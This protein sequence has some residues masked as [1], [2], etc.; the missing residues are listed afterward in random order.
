MANKKKVYKI[1]FGKDL[2]VQE[3]LQEVQAT[4]K[5]RRGGGEE[6]GISLYFSLYLSIFIFS[7]HYILIGKK[8]EV[9]LRLFDIFERNMVFIFL[10]AS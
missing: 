2:T 10:F 7:Y 3:G 5:R 6:G 9:S 4:N 8:V 1:L